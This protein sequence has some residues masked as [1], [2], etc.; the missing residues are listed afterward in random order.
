[1]MDIIADEYDREELFIRVNSIDTGP[2]NTQMR[3]LNF[4]LE[5]NRTLANPDAVIGPYL[6][7]MGVDAG[8]RTAEHIK[9]E[10]L[11]VDAGTHNDTEQQ[12]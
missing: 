9:Y 8:K 6:Y 2:L 12:E 1:M 3:R 11:E 5:D 7:F 4:P 10:R